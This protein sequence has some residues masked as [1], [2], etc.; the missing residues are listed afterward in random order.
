M[1]KALIIGLVPVLLIAVAAI[2][3]RLVPL[4]SLRAPLEK[5]V[6]RGLG[7]GVHIAG[8][9]HA[10]LYPEIGLTAGEVSIENVPGGEAREFAHV[11]TLAV[12]ARLIPLLSREID[13]TRLALQDPT[14]HLEVDQSGNPNWNFAT[15][16]S[17]AGNTSAPSQLSISGLKISG[18]EISY[19]DARTGKHKALG[20]VTASL[21]LAAMDQPATLDLGGL[22]NNEKF[23]VTGR[24]DSPATYLQKK[25]TK[26]VLDVNSRLLNLHFDGTVI[27][28]T[29][30]SGMVKMSGPS[31]RQLMQGAGATAPDTSGLGAFSLDGAVSSNDRVYA[32]SN[33][34]LSLD[35]MKAGL[36]LA[37]DMSG[38][39]PLLKGK[40]ALDR[41]DAGAY[42]M[43][44]E[45]QAKTAG[46][47]T[48]PLSLDGLKLADADVAITVEHFLLGTFVVSHAAMHVAL[49]DAKL[50]ADLTQ[51]ALFNGSATGR[52]T[53][54]AGGA[55]PAFAIRAD[56]K[57]VAMKAL[58][59]S[60][61][62]VE[63]IEGT[64]LLAMD[65]T[66]HG[67]NQQ[68]IVNSLSGTGSATVRNGAIRSVDLAAVARTVQT[69]CRA[70]W[71]P[72]QAEVQVP[73]SRK[74]AASS[75]SE[76]G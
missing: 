76:T 58:L 43:G 72:R 11:G 40:I 16:K 56:V 29:Q 3:A 5:A 69:P 27:G 4:D 38:K 65:V 35:N 46:W 33:A 62:K 48:K 66:G 2:A 41:L 21:G 68:A 60:A 73:I 39:V 6:S 20:Q 36:D 19:F 10:S 63:R 22:F 59:Q 8:P 37:V 26:V 74:Q 64:G 28:A 45:P 9:L 25:P 23:T 50:T 14:I 13:I 30:S 47:S 44:K 75:S 34:R 61:M 18:G 55:V 31:L 32:L 71:G 67:A 24:I 12:G 7:R 70:L 15:T 54:D 1:R 49:Q 57:S 51:A 52:V 42:M 53:A 17:D